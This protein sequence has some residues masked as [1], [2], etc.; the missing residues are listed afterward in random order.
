[1]AIVREHN[2]DIAA[3]SLSDGGA[4]FTVS[5]PVCKQPV[6]LVDEHPVSFRPPICPLLHWPCSPESECW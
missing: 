1:M 4:V 5:L 6:V 2:G 3:Q